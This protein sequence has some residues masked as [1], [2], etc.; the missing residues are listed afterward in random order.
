MTIKELIASLATF[1][2]ST[3]VYQ[4]ADAEGNGYMPVDEVVETAPGIVIIYPAHEYVEDEDEL[5]DD[6]TAITQLNKLLSST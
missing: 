3:K 4:S 6:A 2:P 1:P 5:F